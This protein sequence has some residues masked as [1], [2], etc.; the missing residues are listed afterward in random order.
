[1]DHR[2]ACWLTRH[3]LGHPPRS[4]AAPR[5]PV[6]S[7]EPAGLRGAWNF[8]V[9]RTCGPR[10]LAGRCGKGRERDRA[11]A[12]GVVEGACD[13]DGDRGTR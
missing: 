3:A 9:V 1:M 10:E 11:Q 7:P 6:S 12:G 13:G 8:T 4:A 2:H 5:L